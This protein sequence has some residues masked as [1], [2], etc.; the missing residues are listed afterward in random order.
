VAALE[1]SCNE[2][3][4]DCD[5]RV[6]EEI[7][8]D[9]DPNH[10]GACNRRCA[11][12]GAFG[13]CV[14]GECTLDSCDVGFY[15]LDGNEANGC[16]YRCL[17]SEPDDMR[18][19]RRDND[20]DGRTDED[21]DVMNDTENCGACGRMCRASHA[22]ASC[23]EGECTLGTCEPGHYDLDGLTATGCEY[24]CTPADPPDETCNLRDEDCDGRVDEGDPGGG[25][26]CGD[27]DGEC[28]AGIE[29]CERGGIVCMG[30]VGPTTE[31]CNGD[32]DD[33]D[34]SVD[35]GNPD[36]GAY[37]GSGEGVCEPGR[38]Q[39]VG[40][41]LVCEGEI[42]GADELCNTIDDDCDA[43]VDEGNPEG[44]ASCGTDTGACVAGTMTCVSGSL[45]CLGSVGASLESCNTVDDDCDTR[46]DEDYSLLTDPRNCGLCGRVCAFANASALC[47]AGSCALGVCAPGFTNPDGLAATGCE[48]ECDFAGAEVCNGRDDDC[49]RRTD[50]GVS[51]PTSFCNPNGVCATSTASC[52]G[53]SGWVCNYPPATYES[54]ETRCDGLDNDCDGRV[55]EPF[56]LVGT[57][58]NNGLLGICRTTGAYECNDD[59]DGVECTAGTGATA[60]TFEQCDGEDD[61]CDG[62]I[63]ESARTRWVE[64]SGTF[65]TRWIF[66]YEA[67]HPDAT[68]TSVGSSTTAACAEPNRLP[69]TN[70]TYEEAQ[71]ACGTVGG[72]LCTEAEW[73]R[74]CQTAA[75][76]ACLYSYSASCGTYDD[77]TC[78]GNDYDPSATAGDQDVVLPTGALPMCYAS[79]TGGN[80]FDMSGNVEEWAQ[81]RTPAGS[82]INP[83]RG[84]SN[85]DSSGGLRCNFN[86]VVAGD[87]FA[88]PNVG[89]R[90]CRSTAPP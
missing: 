33:C 73:Q 35:E 75:G 41:A 25:A 64:F 68:S 19:D 45:A 38:E 89:F 86:F 11:P 30:S 67:S 72:R 3:D 70:V 61:D 49:D 6:D 82:N 13:V 88:T 9:R 26:A 36:S 23:T 81:E 76:T 39:C 2:R 77:D 48:Y 74:A 17:A 52:G 28:T 85:N 8:T 66:P 10:C 50:E 60:L 62:R 90:C 31:A 69:W 51:P 55:D 7:D 87:T 56:P 32:D 63:D 78:N 15:D 44:G 65:G 53:A 71:T 29:R 58:C 54:T 79:W 59:E 18:C 34:G 42:T 16:E 80:I 20:C 47:S 22:A 46:I 21:V 27:D 5:G 57:S 12:A 83:L 43:N 14:E 24:A 84:G 4:D 40:G 1:E 37:C